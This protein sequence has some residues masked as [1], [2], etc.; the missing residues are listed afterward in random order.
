M[1]QRAI[2]II[3]VGALSILFGALFPSPLRAASAWETCNTAKTARNAAWD[4]AIK[5]CQKVI[6]K[7]KD[8]QRLAIAQYYLAENLGHSYYAFLK[9]RR[10]DPCNFDKDNFS[11]QDEHIMQSG[12]CYGDS[13]ALAYDKFDYLLSY[14]VQRIA[15]PTTTSYD[16][17]LGAYD[18][19][20]ALG[21][22]NE[23]IVKGRDEFIR[24]REDLFGG[25]QSSSRN[26]YGA[27]FDVTAQ[28]ANDYFRDGDFS[29]AK[30]SLDQ[31]IAA[32]LFASQAESFR[33]N[34]YFM[35]GV[36]L[37]R[38]NNP[39]DA[40]ADFTRSI[41]VR[42]DWNVY[43]QRGLANGA[44]GEAEKA[45]M[46]LSSAI[47]TAPDDA[48]AKAEILLQRA[49][50]HYAMNDAGKA[51]KDLNAAI[52]L[53]EAAVLYGARGEIYLHQKSYENARADLDRAVTLEMQG[54]KERIAR[55]LTLRAAAATYLGDMKAAMSDYSQIIESPN[56]TT[57]DR[58][59][60]HLSVAILLHSS[61][62]RSWAMREYDLVFP[63]LNEAHEQT[64]MKAAAIV[65]AL[66][67]AGL[68]SGE[69]DVYDEALEAALRKCV[70]MLSCRF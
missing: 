44:L 42:P 27:Q 38:M 56:A 66:K 10:T 51:L 24:T 23:M 32:P 16:D 8:K 49:N 63:H 21:P 25:A 15:E 29:D 62:D 5:A 47:S 57:A 64:R 12:I 7:E 34:A 30:T 4:V 36:S 35:R 13:F 20:L 50:Q 65:D 55:F 19:A 46:D 6:R 61:L 43:F 39:S 40:I 70:S 18:K 45:I 48:S 53:R 31:L 68:Y 28:K 22:A 60:A 2:F 37:L 1:S 54:D 41:S 17:A 67:R 26:D 11:F 9:T 69:G 58:L 3:L 33:Q 59:D 14:F 52:A